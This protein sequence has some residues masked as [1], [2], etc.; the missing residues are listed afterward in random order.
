MRDGPSGVLMLLLIVAVAMATVITLVLLTRRKNR[1]LA[2]VV[3]KK[4]AITTW[5]VDALSGILETLMWIDL[6]GFT[7]LGG[8]LGAIGIS[9]ANGNSIVGFFLGI[10]L[11]AI[12][13]FIANVLL[14]WMAIFVDI[15][16]HI[17]KNVDK[18]Q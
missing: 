2:T 1:K 7:I 15:R 12:T 14:A 18:E 10:I 13:G 16:N 3:M 6:I 5:F 4:Y 17:K 8:I 11:G 9:A